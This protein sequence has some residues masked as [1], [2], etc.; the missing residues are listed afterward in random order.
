MT[1]FA[2]VVDA[3]WSDPQA[4]SIGPYVL[5]SLGLFAT[6][7]FATLGYL[8]WRGAGRSYV[9]AASLLMTIVSAFAL[10][11]GL[12]VLLITEQPWHVWFPPCIFGFFGIIIFGPMPLYAIIIHRHFEQR[13]L[14]A[15]LLREEWTE[16]RSQLE[17]LS[18]RRTA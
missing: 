17:G 7:L 18:D 8:G 14:G 10:T 15:R 3:W 12:V 6:S 11:L 5:G 16:D 13:Q 9:I 4:E 2:T 1:L